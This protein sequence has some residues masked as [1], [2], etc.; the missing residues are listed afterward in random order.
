MLPGTR[1]STNTLDGIN[2]TN[3]SWV[4]VYNNTA[5]DNHENGI[6]VYNS[7]DVNLTLNT[8]YNN[9]ANGILLDQVTHSNVTGNNA[10]Y[11]GLSRNQPHELELEQRP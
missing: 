4:T 11:N 2:L 8:A 7:H 5:Y 10:S 6:G 1:R 9:T 3:S